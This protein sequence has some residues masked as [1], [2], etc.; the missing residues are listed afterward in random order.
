MCATA[1]HRTGTCG[2]VLAVPRGGLGPKIN[3]LVR[4]HR[5]GSTPRVSVIIGVYNAEPYLDD[6]IRSVVEQ[7]YRDWELIVVDDGS[8]DQSGAIAD[9]WAVR[10][11]RI[12]VIHQPNSGLPAIPAALPGVARSD[13]A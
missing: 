11:P 4:G 10:E 6:T 3:S 9:R 7:T 13:S 1:K 12:R 5:M 2:L 8:T